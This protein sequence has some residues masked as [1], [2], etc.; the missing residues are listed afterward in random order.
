MRI[1]KIQD[2]LKKVGANAILLTTNVNLFYTLGKI[3]NGYFYIPADGKPWLFVRKPVGIKGENVVYIRKPEDIL[4]YLQEAG[5][6]VSGKVCLED[7][8][9][10]A[11]EWL[12]L[13]KMFDAMPGTALMRKVRSIK[14]DDEIEHIRLAA[15]QQI[16]VYKQIP[17]IFK[18]GMTDFDFS[19]EIEY[20]LRKAGHL[21]VFR[22]FGIRMEAHMGVV[23]SGDNAGFPSAYDFS[24]GGEGVHPSLPL[25]LNNKPIEEGTTVLV[26]MS[27]NHGGYLS[28]I[29]RVF[30]VGSIPDEAYK[31]HEVS[32]LIL[33][34]IAEKA[35]GK[36]C[37]EM[38]NLTLD[39]VKKHDLMDC[40]MGIDQQAK[41]VGHGLGLEINEPPVLCDRNKAVIEEN[42]V[43]AL[44]PKFI[45]K[46]VGAVGIENTYLVKKGGMENL[47]PLNEEIIKIG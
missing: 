26:D 11:A 3:V 43:L 33:R 30:S 37:E 17:Q 10:T 18:M 44:E 28:D 29:T 40:F 41:F 20:R 34:E 15:K 7:D 22:A 39:I 45:I 35:L 31:A 9:L 23:L 47:T 25:G 5:I 24:L 1:Q 14:S 27:G 2:E 46:G 4:E 19:V 36:T 32:I 6:D 38:W 12:R 42:M 13:S 21:G 8:A 16:E